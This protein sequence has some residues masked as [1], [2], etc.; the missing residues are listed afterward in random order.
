SLPLCTWGCCQRANRKNTGPVWEPR[1]VETGRVERPAPP[2]APVRSKNLL[3][4]VKMHNPLCSGQQEK[5]F[6][7]RMSAQ[8]MCL[9]SSC[10]CVCALCTNTRQPTFVTLSLGFCSTG[11]YTY[12]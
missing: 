5:K 3:D 8:A 4:P 7:V 10:S 11:R 2:F 1:E 6:G 12:Q 9:S